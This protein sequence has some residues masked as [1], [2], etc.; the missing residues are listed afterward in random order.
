MAEVIVVE[1]LGDARCQVT[2]T[3]VLPRSGPA[4][5]LVYRLPVRPAIERIVRA[6]LADLA[7]RAE[8]D[9]AGRA[10]PRCQ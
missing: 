8:V 3:G 4:V 7:R 2:Y 1:P 9:G 5:R 6:H 10:H